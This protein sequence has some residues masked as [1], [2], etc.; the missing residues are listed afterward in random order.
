MWLLVATVWIVRAHY[1]VCMCVLSLEMEEVVFYNY[2][3]CWMLTYDNAD[4]HFMH[5][6]WCAV[7]NIGSRTQSYGISSYMRTHNLPVT[8]HLH[9]VIF[10]KIVTIKGLARYELSVLYLCISTLLYLM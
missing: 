7:Y 2:I 5:Y 3:Q 8:A 9:C 1:N 6:Y 4:K 10:R